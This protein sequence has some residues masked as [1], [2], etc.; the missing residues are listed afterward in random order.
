MK[1]VELICSPLP[2]EIRICS[3]V[4]V[5]VLVLFLESALDD[6]KPLTIDSPELNWKLVHN[7]LGGKLDAHV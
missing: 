7:G 3:G 2:T 4:G 5:V 1:V 6:E